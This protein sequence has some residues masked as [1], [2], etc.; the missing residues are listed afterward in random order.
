MQTDN[1]NLI[2]PY[3]NVGFDFPSTTVCQKICGE[4][5][6]GV[7]CFDADLLSWEK[8]LKNETFPD[9]KNYLIFPGSRMVGAIILL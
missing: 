8:A 6:C 1:V 5:K 9:A 4:K 7:V 2:Q 3:I